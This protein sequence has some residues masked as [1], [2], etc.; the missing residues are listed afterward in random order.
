MT[1]LDLYHHVDEVDRPYGTAPSRL[2]TLALNSGERC[3]FFDL[4]FTVPR[5]DD[6]RSSIASG[7][8]LCLG[9]GVADSDVVM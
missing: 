9:L 8:A 3:H 4:D 5:R 6:L 7:F 2:S 1:V